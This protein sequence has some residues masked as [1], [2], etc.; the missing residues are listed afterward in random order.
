MSFSVNATKMP[1]CFEIVPDIFTDER[2]LFV[3][4]FHC[5][6][7]AALGFQTVFVEE[8]YS[9]SHK[10]VLRGLHFQTPP[11]DHTKLVCCLD[12]E[13]FDAVVDLRVGSPTYGCY[14]TFSLSAA[15]ANM[16]YIPPGIAHGF[17]VMSDDALL[18]YKVTTVYSP[19]HDSGILWNSVGIPWPSSDPVISKRDKGF[20]PFAEFASPFTYSAQGK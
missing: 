3:K 11:L 8:Y 2:G 10:Y 6:Q 4:T 19:E 14:Q 9:R 13:V 1:G 5:D 18:L 12:G 7:F 16:L 20:P 17:A 15:K